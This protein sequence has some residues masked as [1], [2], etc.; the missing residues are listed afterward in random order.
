MTLSALTYRSIRLVLRPIVRLLIK[1]GHGYAEVLEA[2]RAEYIDVAKENLVKQGFDVNASRLSAA[3]GIGRREVGKALK[4]P[5]TTNHQATLAG[6][7]IGAWEQSKKYKD[8]VGLPK[9]LKASGRD[10]EFFNLVESVTKDMNPYTMLFELE[11]TG[12]IEWI[13]KENIILK[14][15]E[16][17]ANTTPETGFEILSIDLNDLTTAVD[18]NIFNTS[19]TPNLHLKTEYTNVRLSAV[20]EIR[21]WLVIEGSKLHN[22]MREFI[23]KYDVDINPTSDQKTGVEADKAGVRVALGTFSKIDIQEGDKTNA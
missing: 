1:H 7:V 12:S 22:A 11:R 20:D 21:K 3:T 17:I 5:I 14:K 6:R 18:D 9:P 8:K 23:A 10:S 16:F 19:Q 13:D 2:L 4:S 15:K